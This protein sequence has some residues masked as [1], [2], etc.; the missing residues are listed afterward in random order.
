MTKTILETCDIWDTDYNS[1]NWEPEFMTIFVTWQ[2]R[3]TLDSICNSCNVFNHILL[4]VVLPDKLKEFVKN[5]IWP[6]HQ[7]LGC[8][9]W[10][11]IFIWEKFCR[12]RFVPS[13]FWWW[14]KQACLP[15]LDRSR[16]NM[17][18]KQA[19]TDTASKNLE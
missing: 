9:F 18:L 12:S 1:D 7:R 15:P 19:R 2:L 8:R 4:V 10:N 6:W 11:G 3:V 16:S 17:A 13:L 5:V 14:D